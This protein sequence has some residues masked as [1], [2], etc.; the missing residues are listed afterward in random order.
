ME[1]NKRF[2]VFEFNMVMG[3]NTHLALEK[4]QFMDGRSNYFETLQEATDAIMDSGRDLEDYTIL[5]I[6]TKDN[7]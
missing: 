6:Y 3:S 2:S 5:P 4:V 1:I 7:Y